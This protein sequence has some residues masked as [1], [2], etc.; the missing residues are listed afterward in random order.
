MKLTHEMGTRSK[1]AA[2]RRAA[3]LRL[4]AWLDRPNMAKTDAAAMLLANATRR[5]ARAVKQRC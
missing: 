5:A 4:G 3:R 1:A 2:I